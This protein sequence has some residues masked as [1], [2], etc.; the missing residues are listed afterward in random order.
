MSE[1]DDYEVAWE[2]RD[3]DEDDEPIGSCDDCDGDLYEDD[4]REIAG[5]RLCGQCAWRRKGA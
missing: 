3:Y 5:L 2:F 1:R 4:M